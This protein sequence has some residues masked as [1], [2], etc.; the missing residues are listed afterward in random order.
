MNKINIIILRELTTRVKKKSFIVMTILMPFL[1][2]LLVMAPVL[3][4]QITGDNQE[5]IA[6][7]DQTGKYAECLKSNKEYVFVR[8]DKMEA[9]LKSDTTDITAILT[10]TAD[11]A[12]N[13]KAATLSSSKEMQLSAVSYIENALGEQVRREKMASYNIPNLDA[14]LDEM[15]QGFTLNTVRW[16][17]DGNESESSGALS[18][19]VGFLFTFLIYTFV[20]SYGGMVMS[21]VMEEKTNRIMEIMVSSVSPFQMMMGKIIGVALVGFVQIAIWAV[22]FAALS[23]GAMYLLGSSASE[24]VQMAASPDVQSP[25]A[26]ASADTSGLGGA[27]FANVAALFGSIPI[28][29]LCIMFVL[30]F[31]GGYLLYASFF[32]AVGAS[33]NTQEDSSQF[34]LPV[35][36]VIVF[37]MYAAIG[38][39]GNTDGPLA[40]W[41]SL[42]PLTSPIVMMVRIPFGV[43]LWQEVLSLV[44]LYGTAIGMVWMA[45][46]IY[47]VGILM[48]GKKP[49]FKDLLKWLTYR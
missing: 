27:D 12:E 23:S 29:E 39:Q 42:F 43:P 35:M 40:F 24:A 10:I 36:I 8:Y 7:I 38:S 4:G 48:Y 20:L 16:D 31:I 47:R 9:S 11:L 33:V 32:A 21:G 30:M 6:V 22:M 46:R 2:V 13:P 18:L 44:L 49:T 28:A 41:S 37:G 3:L 14:I 1:M 5:R 15:D 19:G 45:G 17:A 26:A 34:T 25:L